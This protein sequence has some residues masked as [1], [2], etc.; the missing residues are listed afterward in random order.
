MT[1]TPFDVPDEPGEQSATVEREITEA[2]KAVLWKVS[3]SLRRERPVLR[4]ATDADKPDF[5]TARKRNGS[6]EGVGI[7]LQSGRVPSRSVHALVTVDQFAHEIILKS[8]YFYPTDF[9]E[10]AWYA[11]VSPHKL[12]G[13]A[14]FIAGRKRAVMASEWR[15]HLSGETGSG[16]SADRQVREAAG[17]VLAAM[18]YRL[19]DTADFAW[20]PVDAVLAS[21]K[22]SNLFVLL[23]T[24]MVV[25]IH[26]H[27]GGL[28]E[29]A[30]NL[31]GEAVVWG[32]A[33]G[34]IRAGRWWRD[35]K[36][37]EHKPRK[38]RQ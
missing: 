30:D 24:L 5:F 22:L 4:P 26:V 25:M 18:R 21:R 13:L 1:L 15:A 14:V 12:T 11:R 10:P 36:P 23:A 9:R 17:F 29:L 27:H 31:E 8:L 33:F 34:L 37:R 6:W 35:V 32:A 16:L 28:Y 38:S 19:Q 3:Q 20:R 2:E 7:E